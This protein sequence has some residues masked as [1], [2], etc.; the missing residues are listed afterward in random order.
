MKR[1]P[2]YSSHK[3]LG[4]RFVEFAGYEMPVLYTSIIE[5]HN[6]V[7]TS[8]GMFDVS[9]MGEIFIRGKDA[10]SFIQYLVTNDI[11]SL[12][13]GQARYTVMVR[14]DGGILDDLLVYCVNEETWFLVV[15]AS[16]I[17]KDFEWITRQNSSCEVSNESESIALIAVQGPEAKRCLES[18]LDASIHDIRY[19]RFREYKWKGH[20]IFC[21]RTGYTGEDGF[22]IYC[23][24]D[25]AD[26]V[27]NTLLEAGRTIDLKPCG[28]GARDTLRL[29][30]GMLLYG[31]DM[32]ETTN[33]YEVGLGWVVKLDKGDF[34]GRDALEHIKSSGP[35]RILKGFELI[36][37]GVPRHGY[38]V[39]SDDD[40]QIG[41]VTSG[42]LAPFIQKPI[43]F[44]LFSTPSPPE[45]FL[46]Q[47]RHA[48]KRAHI[49]TLPFYKRKKESRQ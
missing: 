16:N 36:D 3:K 23:P 10:R 11:R 8:A 25:I 44:V 37:K 9:H 20:S 21:S 39:F 14:E 31:Q 19:Y 13:P 45:T 49:V 40:H 4:A 18:F 5:E 46:V 6:A 26:A 12:L 7:R 34:I 42:T 2:I 48:K 27:W 28:L 22:E 33:P 15:N 24:S 30:A 32:D 17:D 41:Q 1:T 38:P 29:E 35:K 43:G 47:I